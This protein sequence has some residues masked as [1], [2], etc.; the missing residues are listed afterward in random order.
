MYD[1]IYL[2]CSVKKKFT[3]T[4]IQVVNQDVIKTTI[5]SI[6]DTNFDLFDK[7]ILR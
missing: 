3:K 1:L 7:N 5:K 6:R 4:N 2:E